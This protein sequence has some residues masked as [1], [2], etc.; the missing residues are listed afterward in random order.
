MT[1]KIKCKY[2]GAKVPK[3]RY[4]DK[5]GKHLVVSSILGDS[6]EMSG[7]DVALSDT[8]YYDGSGW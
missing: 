5:C 4:C 3:K 2:C 6:D 8:S 1:E 7:S